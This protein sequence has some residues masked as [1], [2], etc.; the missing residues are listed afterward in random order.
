VVIKNEDTYVGAVYV[1]LVRVKTWLDLIL[2]LIKMEIDYYIIKG[3]RKI[4]LNE[5]EVKVSDKI[6]SA[7]LGP[8]ITVCVLKERTPPPQNFSPENLKGFFFYFIFNYFYFFLILYI[9]IPF[10]I[11]PPFHLICIS[12]FIFFLSLPIT[13]I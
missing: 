12:L 7:I 1:S 8:I 6:P 4:L 5:I 10:L 3:V 13:L 9:Y 2:K 11:I